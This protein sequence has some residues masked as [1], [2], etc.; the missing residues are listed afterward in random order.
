MNYDQVALK[1]GTDKASSHHG[2]MGVYQQLLEHRKVE[3]LFEIGCA[4][5]KSLWM[6]HE[7]FP[8]A[9]IVGCDIVEEC[10]LHQRKKVAVLIAD[11][12]DAS[13]MAAVSQLHGPFDVIVDDGEHNKETI[14]PAFEE[15][16]PRLSP[17]GVYIIED[18]KPDD[19]VEAWANDF[20]QQWGGTYYKT[21]NAGLIVVE[22][23]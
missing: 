19:P 20:M 14:V 15:L 16:Y 9:L 12:R 13:K 10:R 18:L 21:K 8:D 2:Y 11:A 1:H 3:R 17:G 7:L 22:H 6:W 23:P 5:G 4:H